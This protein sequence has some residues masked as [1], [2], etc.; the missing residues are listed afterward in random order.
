MEKYKVEGLIWQNG[1]SIEAQILPEKLTLLQCS[2]QTGS[3]CY[4]IIKIN[5][6]LLQTV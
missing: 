3:K 5:I 2:T 1:V 6:K 4:I